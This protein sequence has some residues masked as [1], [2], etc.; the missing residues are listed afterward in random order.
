MFNKIEKPT[1]PMAVINQ[2]LHA[3]SENKLIPG[4]K[5]P[6]ERELVELFQISRP[7]IRE[8]VTALNFLG[9]IQKRWGGGNY[10]SENLNISIIS[11][12]LQYLVISK[13]KEVRD[14]LEARKAVETELIALA[15]LRRKETHILEMHRNLLDLKNCKSNC[16]KRVQIDYDFHKIIGRAATNKILYGLQLALSEKVIQIMEIGVY[17]PEALTDTETEHELMLKAIID[18][19]ASEGRSVMATHIKK[20]EQRY[21]NNLEKIRTLNNEK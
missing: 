15:A 13:E 8:G 12:S 18:S 6:S 3:I 11:N 14:L 16:D 4:Q 1:T 7:V 10:I 2:I 19:N 17:L 9:I 5:L 21:I 20:L